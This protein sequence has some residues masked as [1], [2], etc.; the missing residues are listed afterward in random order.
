[1][2]FDNDLFY[3]SVNSAA[4]ETHQ[5]HNSEQSSSA[6]PRKESGAIALKK[7][8]PLKLNGYIKLMHTL[9]FISLNWKCND[10]EELLTD[11]WKVMGGTNENSIKAE[12]LMVVLA[13]IMNLKMP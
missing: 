3:S 5:E 2:F 9:G 4:S 11:L 1:M 7:G 12:N 13:A 10:E 8:T 6:S